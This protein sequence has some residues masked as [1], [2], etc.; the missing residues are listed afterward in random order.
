LN[1]EDL[2]FLTK[3]RNDNSRKKTY[4]IL[5]DLRVIQFFPPPTDELI[6]SA[7]NLSHP[8]PINFV[9]RICKESIILG[10]EP[11]ENTIVKNTNYEDPIATA[12]ELEK[13]RLIDYKATVEIT[14]KGNKTVRH[15][16]QKTAQESFVIKVLKSLNL[17]E[18]ANSIIAALKS[19]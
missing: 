7:V 4:E 19:T 13:H 5:K 3:N 18:I 16:I 9:E 10:H 6:L 12:K 8:Q 17:P 1:L 2:S 11:T 14:P 15:T